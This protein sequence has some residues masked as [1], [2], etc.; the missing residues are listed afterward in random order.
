[1]IAHLDSAPAASLPPSVLSKPGVAAVR[2]TICGKPVHTVP[3]RILNQKSGFG[4]KLLCDGATFTAGTACVYRCQFCFVEPMFCRNVVVRSLLKREGAEFGDV[5]IRRQD[6][7]N[8]IRAELTRRDGS[9]KFS[10]PADNRV[11]FGSPLVDIAPTVE[12]ADETAAVCLQILELTHW[13]IRLLSKSPL[14]TR[15]AQAIPEKHKQRVIFGLST[16]T[17]DDRVAAAIERGAPLVSKRIAALHWLQDHG[18]RTFAMLCP[19]LPQ[20]DYAA[21]S[22]KLCDAVRV[23][24]CEHVWTEVLNARGLALTRTCDALDQ[25]G[26][27]AEAAALLEVSRNK[28]KWEAYARATFAAHARNVAPEKLRFLQY[29]SKASRDWWAERAGEGAILLG[30]SATAVR[31]QE[32]QS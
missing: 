29:V 6:P 5:V 27:K 12:L 11:I 19:S 15:I 7:V 2:Q 10:D 26:F 21:F 16:G 32:V 30:R 9:P 23:D 18:Y 1:M 3:S 20:R 4:H 14:I 31:K 28:K 25:A 8:K 22:K 17:L 24:R 13:Q